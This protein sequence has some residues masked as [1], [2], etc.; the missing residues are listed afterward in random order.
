MCLKGID[1]QRSK[2]HIVP[3][4]ISEVAGRPSSVENNDQLARFCTECMPVVSKSAC[5]IQD[6]GAE[7]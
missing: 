6:F 3:D 1:L 5:S 7:I 4:Q 2:K